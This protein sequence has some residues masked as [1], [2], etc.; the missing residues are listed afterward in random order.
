GDLAFGAPFG[1]LAS[2][3]HVVEMRKD[4][5]APPVIVNAAEVL[6]RRGEVAATLGTMP[7]LIPWAKWLPD[8]FFRQRA[9]AISSLG[10]IAVSAVKRRRDMRGTSEERNDR[11]TRLIEGKDAHGHKLGRQE[12]TGEALTLI[13]AGS[14]TTSN[15]F[16]ALLYWALRT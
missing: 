12:L 7:S 13:T 1:I 8:P 14:D 9:E 16:C 6:S 11:L 10:G 3:R 2:D 15:T 5:G 4:P